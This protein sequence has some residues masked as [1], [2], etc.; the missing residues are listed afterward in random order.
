[1]T[2]DVSGAPVWFDAGPE[3]NETQDGSESRRRFA[4]VDGDAWFIEQA[5][6]HQT[7]RERPYEAAVMPHSFLNAATYTHSM[8][9]WTVPDDL[10][11]ITLDRD[12]PLEAVMPI[13]E[14]TL[15]RVG[16]LWLLGH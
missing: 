9:G 13:G 3:V 14:A 10:K 12:K 2:S 8:Q 11:A 7:Q 6:I 16:E 5:P 4:V 1:M 15:I